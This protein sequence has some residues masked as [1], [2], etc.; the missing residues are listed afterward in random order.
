MKIINR[1]INEYHFLS[2]FY[3]CEINYD[4]II[5]PSVEN[6][7]QANKSLDYNIKIK[8]KNITSIEAKK[9]G[10]VIKLRPDFD[11]VKL[12]I[13]EQ[14]LLL[15]FQIP[16]L[17]ANL[18]STDGCLLIEGNYWNDLF[19]GKCLKTNRGENNLGKLLMKIRDEIKNKKI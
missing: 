12:N 13:M 18:L 7:Y 19:W 3:P 6:A 11:S 17:K 5:Y 16:Q 9:L 10:R 2:N 1:F 14:L 15:K 8:F 4:N